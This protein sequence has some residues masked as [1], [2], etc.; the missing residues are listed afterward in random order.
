Q[1]VRCALHSVR[2][3]THRSPLDS[4]ECNG[5]GHLNFTKNLVLFLFTF[6]MKARK[7]CNFNNHAAFS[8]NHHYVVNNSGL[9]QLIA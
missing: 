1:G 8:R 7:L 5:L 6:Q 3:E 2:S 9:I 4:A